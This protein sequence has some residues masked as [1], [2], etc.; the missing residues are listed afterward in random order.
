MGSM[1]TLD[2]AL[3]GPRLASNDSGTPLVDADKYPEQAMGWPSFWPETPEICF[4]ANATT[5][6]SGIGWDDTAFDPRVPQHTVAVDSQFDWEV[7]K[8]LINWTLLYLPENEK[9]HWLNSLRIWEIGADADPRFE[10][11]IEFHDPFGKIFVAKTYGKED[12][13]GRTVQKGIGARVLEFANQLLNLGYVVD[14]DVVAHPELDPDGDGTAD[15]CLPVLDPTT[16]TTI[17]K[18]EPGMQFVNDAGA[19]VSYVPGCG[20]NPSTGLI[21]EDDCPCSANRACVKLERYVT[22]PYYLRQSMAAYG[23]IDPEMR[24]VYE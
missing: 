20:L 24:G 4:P 6:C 23:L 14:C 16:G 17:V 11:R 13:F 21:E 5:I 2:E 7:Q 22:V 12:I 19:F 8:F 9:Q 10:N 15:W 1:L 18:Y 3:K